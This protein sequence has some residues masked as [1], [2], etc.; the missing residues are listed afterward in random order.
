MLS[1]QHRS[2]T[3]T[4]RTSERCKPQ[5]PHSLRLE[6][7]HLDV[8][9]H[10][11]LA[12]DS[13]ADLSALIHASPIFFQQYRSNRALWLSNSLQLELDPVITDAYTVHLSNNPKFRL[14]R[15]EKQIQEF[16]KVYQLRRSTGIGTQLV[17]LENGEIFHAVA[18]Y[19][20][21]VKPLVS[22]YVRWAQGNH[23]GLS[24]SGQL[25]KTEKTRI[26]RGFYRFQLFCNLFG[27]DGVSGRFFSRQEQRLGHFL[28]NFEP[29]EIEEIMCIYWFAETKYRTVLKEVAWDFDEDNPKFDVQRKDPYVPEGTYHLDIFGDLYRN[30]LNSLGLP[31]LASIFQARDHDELVETVAKNIISGDSQWIDMTTD[32]LAQKQRRDRLFSDRDR[33]Q[34]RRDAMPF[35]GDKEN[36]PPLAWVTLWKETYSNL[37]GSYIPDG[38]RDWG[39]VMWDAARLVSSGAVAT[40]EDGAS[41]DGYTGWSGDFNDPRDSI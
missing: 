21:V 13:I 28:D 34:Q 40:L 3:S 11:L 22:N 24:A 4:F 7:L 41:K 16:I 33:A 14:K 18:F 6:D 31:V 2:L 5:E 37:Y 35:K 30:G 8:R 27:S 9:H 12:I 20:S 26:V 15:S 25:S 19:S 39:Y 38:F 32:E 23:R 10:I 29:W 17:F 36:L 1:S